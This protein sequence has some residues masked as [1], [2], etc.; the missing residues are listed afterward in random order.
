MSPRTGLNRALLTALKSSQT[1]LTLKQVSFLY[2]NLTKVKKKLG[3]RFRSM[4]A[5]SFINIAKSF[6]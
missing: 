2:H 1:R 4:H 6:E 3:Y 5:S